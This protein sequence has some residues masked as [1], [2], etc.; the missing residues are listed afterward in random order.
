MEVSI[1][2]GVQQVGAS[3]SIPS[4]GSWLLKGK[5][6]HVVFYAMQDLSKRSRFH[7]VL[8]FFFGTFFITKKIGF[9]CILGVLFLENAYVSG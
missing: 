3:G 5:S 6:T 9:T 2:E 7:M 8:P 1:Y 4:V